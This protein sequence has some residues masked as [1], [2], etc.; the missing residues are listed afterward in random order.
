MSARFACGGFERAGEL[1]VDQQRQAGG[2]EDGRGVAQGLFVEEAEA[3]AAGVDEKTFV[4]G[5]AGFGEWSEVQ[6]VAVAGDAFDSPPGAPVDPALA[7][8]GRALGFE[9]G[10][11]GSGRQ[12]VEGHVDDGGDAA[13]GGGAGG[14][15]EAFPFG[16]AGLVDVDVRVDEAGED[17]VVA[18][19]VDDGVGWWRVGDGGDAAFRDD[20]AGGTDAFGENDSLRDVGG[21]GHLD[22]EAGPLIAMRLR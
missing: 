17:G 19:V 3:F 22:S 21:L 5:D 4:A 10:D 13:G 8:G 15:G 6:L 18:D 12:A 20:D 16:A 2:G 7:G 11:G 1:G 14:G 9:A